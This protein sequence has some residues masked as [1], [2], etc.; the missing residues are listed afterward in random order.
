MM[1]SVILDQQ[2]CKRV[3]KRHCYIPTKMTKNIYFIKLTICNDSDNEV[4]PELPCR[5]TVKAIVTLEVLWS[6]TTRF[7][8]LLWP[9]I[10]L[11]VLYCADMSNYIETHTGRAKS[12]SPVKPAGRMAVYPYNENYPVGKNETTVTFRHMDAFQK[13]NISKRWQNWGWLDASA[14]SRHMPGSLKT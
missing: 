10:F 8:S 2:E 1:L 11:Q 14:E 3:T 6:A 13:S 7:V 12:W 5:C 9:A 4:W